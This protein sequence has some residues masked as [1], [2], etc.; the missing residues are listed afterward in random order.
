MELINIIVFSMIGAILMFRIQPFIYKQG[1]IWQPNQEDSQT[2]LES[3][4][5][6]EYTMAAL[7]IFAVSL[8]CTFVWYFMASRSQAHRPKQIQQWRGCWAIIAVIP[9]LS[10]GVGIGFFNQVSEMRLSLAVFFLIDIL[11]LFWLTTATS[12]PGLLI[13]TPPLAME[14][15]NLLS[16]LGVKE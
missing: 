10:I 6:G 4:V 3:W 11:I 7:W 8:L 13:Y 5:S 1:L 16:K 2:T 14:L 15:R 12:T 9:V